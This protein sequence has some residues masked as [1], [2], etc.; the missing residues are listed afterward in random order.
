MADEFQIVPYRVRS[1]GTDVPPEEV[2]AG[3]NSLAFQTQVALNV[4]AGQSQAPTGP[5]G[6]DLGGT[7]P[8][9]QV[10]AVHATSGSLTGVSIIN[11]TISG[12]TGVTGTGIDNTTAL[13]TDAFVNQ[14][15]IRFSANVPLHITGG[16]YNQAVTGTG[17]Q[18]VIFASGGVISSVVSVITGGI[19]YAVGDMLLVQ[20]GNYDARL[21]VTNVVGGAI[22]S[23]GLEVLYGGTGYSTGATVQ[24]ADVPPGQ[25]TITMTGILTSN[26]TYILA[27][28]TFN[29]ASRRPE[30]VNNTTGA[31]TVTVK[32]SN[33]LGGSTGTGVVL[34][35]GTNN[36]TAVTLMTDGSTDVWLADPAAGIGAAVTSGTLAQFA[37][38]TSAQLAGVISDETGSGGLVFATGSVI[39][40]TSTGAT[41]PGSGAFTTL[42]ATTPVGVASGGTGRATLTNHGVL[43]G[44]GTAAITQSAV[45]TTGQALIGQTGADPIF[46]F[47]T[48]ALIGVQV[49]TSTQTYTP[50]TGTNSVVVELQS[51][52]GG[53]GGIAA[54]AAGTIS[55]STGSGSGAY[56]KVRFTTGFSGVTVTIG[57]VGAAGTSAPG[58]GGNGATSSFGALIS[59]PGGNGTGAAAATSTAGGMTAGAAQ[60]AAPTISG[61][62]TIVSVA[63]AGTSPSF[64]LTAAQAFSSN[65][66]SSMLGVGGSQQ[67]TNTQ[68]ATA[69][70]GFGAGASSAINGNSQAAQA[71]AAGRPA[72]CIVYEY[73]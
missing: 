44:A 73:A 20:G 26:V 24:A 18:F 59:C 37:P 32:I 2:Q 22:Q 38:T 69:G 39:N 19:N 9:P 40:P 12:T 56:A 14:Q 57:A 27:N 34:P 7:Y 52:G 10:V 6:G 42:T 17:V 58:A 60:T 61:G 53:S 65:G 8:N 16:T 67:N 45:G 64:L 71:G 47:P 1:A 51:A 3:L 21:R 25:R 23:G 36:S 35:Q 41:T 33:G 50:T 63:G 68:P 62:T 28:G 11:G 49:I 15:I 46:G 13:A 55:A 43:I 30:F 4:L 48:G 72:V 54:T 66:A 29:N 5:A 70:S 31:F